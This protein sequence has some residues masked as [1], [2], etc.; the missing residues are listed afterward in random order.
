MPQKSNEITL[1]SGRT[2]SVRSAKG[3]DM[4]AA[5]RLCGVGESQIGFMLALVATCTKVDGEAVQYEELL[6]WSNTELQPLMA[7]MGNAQSLATKI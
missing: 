2:A 6:D 7:V 4:I 3:R 5:E 1:P